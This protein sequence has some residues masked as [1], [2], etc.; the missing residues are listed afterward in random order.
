MSH[1]GH[2]NELFWS[3]LALHLA[4]DPMAIDQREAALHWL[5]E[6]AAAPERGQQRRKIVCALEDGIL[7]TLQMDREQGFTVEE[8][9]GSVIQLLL[10]LMA[11]PLLEE[12][13]PTFRRCLGY[14]L[15]L[16]YGGGE[17]KNSFN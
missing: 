14:L 9:R 10:P 12:T 8:F 4:W 1:W 6:V 11:G 7:Q 15:A 5:G 3:S 2:L 17:R 13:E 16:P